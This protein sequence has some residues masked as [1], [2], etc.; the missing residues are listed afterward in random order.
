MRAAFALIALAACN[1]GAIELK[2]LLPQ[3]SADFDMTCIGAVDVLPLGPSDSKPLDIGARTKTDTV[4]CVD[5]GRQVTTFAQLQ[6]A[7]ANRVDIGIPPGGLAAVEVRGRAGKCSDKPATFEAIFYGGA[8]YSGN[9][10]LTIPVARNVSCGASTQFTVK[11]VNMFDLFTTKMCTD[12]VDAASQAFSADLR[13]TLI[14]R[15]PLAFEIGESTQPM[16]AATAQIMSFNAAYK[17]TCAAIALQNSAM[18]LAGQSCINAGGATACAGANVELAL[19][20]TAYAQASKDPA[21]TK[22]SAWNFIGVWTTTGTAGPLGGATVTLDQGVDA[23]VV[24]G[25][26]GTSAFQPSAGAM[27]TT[28]TG[29][30]MVYTNAVVG[31][32]VSATGKS[33]RHLYIGADPNFPSSQIAVLN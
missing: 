15:Q 2:L 8:E 18:T 32:T 7:L 17:G 1:D 9:D 31:V 5:L 24:Y 27:M 30:V 12:Y 11:P 20:P 19:L 23:K 22:Y 13:P 25:D 28:A 21:I 26:L 3:E 4:P 10:A 16:S 6:A 14:R 33:S 29:M